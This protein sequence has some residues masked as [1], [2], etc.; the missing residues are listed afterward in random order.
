MTDENDVEKKKNF[1]L[2]KVS[3]QK[4]DGLNTKAGDGGLATSTRRKV[5]VKVKRSPTQERK[6]IE[7]PSVQ[8]NIANDEGGR[9][10]VTV[11]SRKKEKNVKE[12]P[13]KEEVKKE[14]EVILET[15]TNK[16]ILLE[17]MNN[18]AK[19]EDSLDSSIEISVDF[20]SKEV[21]INTDANIEE[22]K[23]K[24]EDKKKEGLSKEKNVRAES[25]KNEV[26]ELSTKKDR[27]ST[28]KDE[29][30]VGDVKKDK[31]EEDNK[32]KSAVS[33]E[34]KEEISSCI[35]RD[36]SASNTQDGQPQRRYGSIDDIN[37]RPNIK[38]GNLSDNA[39]KYR[40]NKKG[41]DAKTGDRQKSAQF[42][43]KKREWSSGQKGQDTK[44]LAGSDNKGNKG[45]L[46]GSKKVFS[47]GMQ[48][49]MVAPIP[50]EVQKQNKKTRGA[51]KDYSRK[52]KEEEFFEEKQIQQKKKVRDKVSAVPQEIQILETISVADL[53]KKMNL[54]ASEII[55]K[56]MENGMMV[57]VNQSIDSDTVQII[58][59][60]YDCNV[61]VVSLYDETI[62]ASA[63]DEG[64]ELKTRPPIV[65]VMGH[66]DHGKTK[67]LDAIRRANVAEGEF[68]GITQHIGAY[69]VSYND[70]L[71]TFLDTPGHE[72]FTMM[73]ARGA[74]I[75]DIVVL[76]V[77][78]DDGVM[79]QTIEAIN[80]AKDAKVPIIVA[81]N[82][83]DKPEA[84]PDKIKTRLS[85]MDL[86]PEDWGGTTMY[87]E[88]SALKKQGIS[89]LL[90]AILLQAEVLELKANYECL[91]EGKVIESK[92]DH[93]RGVVA[94]IIVQ[95]GIL[96]EGDPYVAGVYAGHV[97]A[98]FDDKGSR[99]QEALPSM[100]CE[101]LGLDEMPNAGDPFQV[102]ESEKQ[103]RQISNKRRE[104]KRFEVA[105]AI[106]KVTLDNLYD[107]IQEGAIL[108]L[109]VIIKADVQGSVEALTQSLEKLSTPE[110]RL[111]V[112]HAS[113]GAINE[114]DVMLAAADSNVIII[115]FNVR[116]TLKA[117]LL[118]ETEKVDIRRYT[119]IYQAVEE[120]KLAME[121]MLS[122]DKK[123]VLVG[124]AEIRNVFKV[125]KVG[126][127]AGIYVLDG[128]IK[129]SYLVNVVR[130]NLVIAHSLKIASLKR[131]KD[132]V[133]E[134]AQGFECGL[135]LEGFNDI[136][137]GDNLEFIEIQEVSRKLDS[138]V[139]E[140]EKSSE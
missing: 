21:S 129:R 52:S 127:V 80:H 1:V 96:K 15:S 128:N 2:E 122:P 111:S 47:F 93:G 71:I 114:S 87:V 101:I 3:S 31:K 11:S 90:E 62:I 7:V 74:S 69:T 102:V 51:K 78:A 121:G 140:A 88:I 92:I 61:K 134:V 36:P 49:S 18:E 24:V 42:G 4:G 39:K 32:Q 70:K 107:T 38:A 108:E 40:Y 30:N 63:N 120:M 29:K 25:E 45:G 131:F 34:A 75:T 136:M 55:A 86:M 89:D 13:I 109:K 138:P 59:S 115:G 97:R 95:K 54:R 79:P 84:N 9:P 81:I 72:A 119:V 50:I 137:T 53:A 85:E 35:I 33:L 8:K 100:P 66:V 5:K 118:A 28:K 139:S 94:S 126:N 103:A 106:K 124:N 20:S 105:K 133:K 43:D 98:I 6:E 56:L 26:S 12:E 113:A 73:R 27:V 104:L 14:E 46:Q 76:V 123:E 22:S 64:V 83:M 65:T 58:A 125:S 23:E 99:I 19:K 77:A 60:D 117:R 68:G 130:D 110:I 91:A 132:D 41:Q 16:D 37:K 10:R 135:S 44:K 82:K 112:I 57:T 116:P 67:T 48:R 17:S